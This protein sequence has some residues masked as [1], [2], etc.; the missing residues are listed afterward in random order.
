[1]AIAVLLAESTP[2]VHASALVMNSVNFRKYARAKFIICH[3]KL[4][5]LHA[6]VAIPQMTSEPPSRRLVLPTHKTKG[7][8]NGTVE[9][10]CCEGL[11][12]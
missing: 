5:A 12:A 1:M 8:A 7:V 4:Q 10:P 3:V 6:W 9:K 11:A 2:F